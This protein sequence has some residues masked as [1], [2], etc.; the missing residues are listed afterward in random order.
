MW[1][2]SKMK[3][4]M[5]ILTCLEKKLRW[6][7]YYMLP[8][9]TQP[10]P[11]IIFPPVNLCRICSK[12]ELYYHQSID[13]KKRFRARGY[14]DSII[15]KGFEIAT[16]KRRRDLLTPKKRPEQETQVRFITIINGCWR[17]M[18]ESLTT[19]WR[20]LEMDLTIKRAITPLE[21]INDLVFFSANL[22]LLGSPYSGVCTSHMCVSACCV[23]MC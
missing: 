3:K 20:L 11:G 5:Y 7:H 23:G 13:L 8:P 15:N 22:F 17:D 1:L 6:T 16:D 21:L 4:V 9:H 19:H 14:R 10:L 2:S 12:D 18:R